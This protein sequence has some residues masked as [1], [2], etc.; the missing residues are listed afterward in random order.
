MWKYTHTDELY[1]YGVLGMK[2]GKRR[3]RREAN[4]AQKT[5]RIRQHNLQRVDKH[6]A[7]FKSKKSA[8]NSKLQS[9]KITQR[10][11][12]KKIQKLDA[13]QAKAERAKKKIKNS[14]Y[15]MTNGEIVARG[16]LTTMRTNLVT[17]LA[18]STATKLGEEKVARLI[19]IGGSAINTG[20]TVKTIVALS[21]NYN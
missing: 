21:K 15:G 3:A 16:I 11:A 2:W 14:R 18:S 10:Q 5:E 20:T 6:V 13:K 19:R 7:E 9:R 17:N 12:D 1:H 4:A 8:I